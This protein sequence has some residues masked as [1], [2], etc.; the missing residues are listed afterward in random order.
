MTAMATIDIAAVHPETRRVAAAVREAY[1]RETPVR[2]VGA[3]TWLDAGRPVAPGALPLPLDAARGIVEYVPGDLTITVLAGTP[4]GEIAAAT[5]AHGQR[6]TL[7]PY[8]TDDGTIGATVATASAGPLASA[9][10]TPRDLVLGATFVSGAGSVI[11][12]GGRVVKNVA[13]FDLVRLVTGAWGTLGAITE[14]T[15]R[16]RSL[17]AAEET[18]AVPLDASDAGAVGRMLTLLRELPFPFDA[19]ELLDAAT[20]RL[21]APAHGGDGMLLARAAGSAALVKAMRAALAAAGEVRELDPGAWARLRALECAGERAG[22]AVLRLS[23][24]PAEAGDAWRAAREIAATHGGRAHLCI[25]RTVVRL[26]VPAVAALAA[27]RDLAPFGGTCIGE[28]LPASA[29][30][31]LDTHRRREP[32]M[33]RARDRLTAG[34]RAAFDPRRILNPGILG[35]AIVA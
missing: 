29:W 21:L 14:L 23:H 5:R 1:E 34:I 3:G 33:Q 28:R 20:A 4:V 19:L 11:R 30:P 35:E 18:L 22:E 27:I 16:L 2:L 32:A 25:G 13:G 12:G 15:L 8:G 6:L 10:G 7:D 9:Y 24:L 26:A 31:L 17:P